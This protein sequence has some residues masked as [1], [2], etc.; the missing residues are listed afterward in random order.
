MSNPNEKGIII[1]ATA[2]ALF[3]LL[4]LAMFGAALIA[5]DTSGKHFTPAERSALCAARSIMATQ[6]NIIERY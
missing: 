6:T 3:A 5:F 1:P 4:M 2:S